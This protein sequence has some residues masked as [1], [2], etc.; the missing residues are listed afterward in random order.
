MYCVSI[1]NYIYISIGLA[2]RI[3][4]SFPL[5]GRDALHP[6]SN[7]PRTP[8]HASVHSHVFIRVTHLV[9]R[10]CEQAIHTHT[11]VCMYMYMY[12]YI[13]NCI[14]IYIDIDLDIC[15]YICIYIYTYMCIYIYMCVYLYMYICIYVFICLYIHIYTYIHMCVCVFVCVCV[16]LCSFDFFVC[17]CCVSICVT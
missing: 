4:F 16:R 3:H 8:A 9:R 11:Y 6:P 12:M 10:R 5:A 14:Y 17:G 2:L 1:P 13:S 7:D 15:T